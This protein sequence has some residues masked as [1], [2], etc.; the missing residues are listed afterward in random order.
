MPGWRGP[1]GRGRALVAACH[2]PPPPHGRAHGEA[3]PW[4]AGQ[5]HQGLRQ[6]GLRL[7]RPSQPWCGGPPAGSRPATRLGLLCLWHRGRSRGRPGPR[8]QASPAG[9]ASLVA[10]PAGHAA[11][12]PPASGLRPHGRAHGEAWPWP[13]VAG[14]TQRAVALLGCYGQPQYR[15]PAGHRA[16]PP[17]PAAQ[18]PEPVAWPH[19]AARSASHPR[20]RPGPPGH[21]SAG[22]GLP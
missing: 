1:A 22:G 5:P 18:G 12:G 8:H 14:S 21:V 19:P 9:Q 13:G 20:R 10:G 2:R 4:L 15:Q 17:V 7:W 11:L 6:P 3:E 16:R